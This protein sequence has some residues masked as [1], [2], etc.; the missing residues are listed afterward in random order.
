M[1]LI[2]TNVERD[3]LLSH[4]DEISPLSGQDLVKEKVSDAHIMYLETSQLSNNT[5]HE[6][7]LKSNIG[8]ASGHHGW[9]LP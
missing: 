9:R 8:E 7:Q 6:K 4:G 5:D 1:S 3:L 2:M